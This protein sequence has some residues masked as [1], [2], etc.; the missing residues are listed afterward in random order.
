M[1]CRQPVS[2]PSGWRWRRCWRALGAFILVA[3]RRRLRSRV[4]DSPDRGTGRGISWPSGRATAADQ[5]QARSRHQEPNCQEGQLDE[6]ERSRTTGRTGEGDGAIRS[7]GG[8]GPTVARCRCLTRHGRGHLSAGSAGSCQR[9]TT[10]TAAATATAA[11]ATATTSWRW[12]PAAE[13]VVL[14]GSVVVV[15]SAP[16]VVVPPSAVVVVP[17]SAVVVPPSAVVVVPLP[18][19]VVVVPPP[20]AVG[21]TVPPSAVVVVPPSS[22][23]SPS[24][25]WSSTPPPNRGRRL[26]LPNRGRRLRLRRRNSVRVMRQAEEV[27]LFG[28]TG[29]CRSESPLPAVTGVA[30]PT[31]DAELDCVTLLDVY[32]DAICYRC[33][34]P[35]VAARAG[36]GIHLRPALRLRARLCSPDERFRVQ[37]PPVGMLRLGPAASVR[38]SAS[39]QSFGTPFRMSRNPSSRSRPHQ[40]CPIIRL[41]EQLIPGWSPSGNAIEACARRCSIRASSSG[42]PGARES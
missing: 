26:L 25:S 3:Y 10:T 36:S 12:P 15:P 28:F 32:L 19:A 16:V 31:L 13:V 20:S 9:G 21:R 30:L 22:W 27:S 33:G 6:I 42:S 40:A 29:V 39:V 35:P 8:C 24:L 17:P 4:T 18:S 41:L 37:P 23:W 38:A 14:P 5:H 7:V 11:T 1:N 2:P 34:G